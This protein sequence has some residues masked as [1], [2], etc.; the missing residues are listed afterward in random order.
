VT[1]LYVAGLELGV[2]DLLGMEVVEA[3]GHLEHAIQGRPP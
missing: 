2:D 3:F 1:Y